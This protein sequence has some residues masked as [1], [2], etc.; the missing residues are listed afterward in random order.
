MVRLLQV[1]GGGWVEGTTLGARYKL[2][3]ERT[4]VADSADPALHYGAKK[5]M[6]DVL[7]EIPGVEMRQNTHLL[8]TYRYVKS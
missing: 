6:A 5:K 1:D 3:H 2:Q 4:V 7:F 8:P